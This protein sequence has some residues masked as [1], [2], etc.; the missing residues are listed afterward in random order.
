MKLVRQIAAVLFFIAGVMFLVGSYG[1]TGFVI[2]G[3]VVGTI[4]PLLGIGL[5]VEGVLTATWANMG[6]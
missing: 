3:D 6:D 2:G 5:L 1:I 4:S